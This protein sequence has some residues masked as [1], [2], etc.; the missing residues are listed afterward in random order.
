VGRGAA[1]GGL[2]G[3]FTG[4][5]IGL[6]S[7]DDDCP[8]GQTCYFQATAGEKALAGGLVF[9][10]AGTIVGVIIGA[11]SR[12]QKI[13]IDGDQKTFQSKKGEISKYVRDHLLKQR[14]L[15]LQR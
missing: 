10:A 11:S 12:A 3:F 1:A 13:S 4:A 14:E 6:A 15:A 8:P 2:T 7:G 9:S 5:I